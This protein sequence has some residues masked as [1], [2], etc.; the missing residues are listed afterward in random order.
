MKYDSDTCNQFVEDMEAA[1]LSVRH[2][3]GRWFWTGPA[4]E[5]ERWQRDDVARATS[6]ALQQ[7][8]MGLGIVVYPRASGNLVDE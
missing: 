8:D 5:V 3:R 6:V 1:G 2:Y 4:V 7:D